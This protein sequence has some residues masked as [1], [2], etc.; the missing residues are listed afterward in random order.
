MDEEYESA[1]I[2]YAEWIET[3]ARLD[4]QQEHIQELE[5][6]LVSIQRE[7]FQI[8]KDASDLVHMLEQSQSHENLRVMMKLFIRTRR[9]R[10]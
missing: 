7:Y 8:E 10:R 4:A 1:S 9:E 6:K 5:E 2:S 3:L